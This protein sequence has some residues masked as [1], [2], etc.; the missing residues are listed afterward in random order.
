[1]NQEFKI[2][3]YIETDTQPVD[4]TLLQGGEQIDLHMADETLKSYAE[5]ASRAAT[6]RTTPELV[7]PTNIFEREAQN[8]VEMVALSAIKTS[9][10]RKERA[11]TPATTVQEIKLGNAASRSTGYDLAA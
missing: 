11:G 3:G 5:I 4:A 7:N 10:F 8:H 2:P 6:L 1:M 9:K